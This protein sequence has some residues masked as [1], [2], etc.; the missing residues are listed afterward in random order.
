MSDLFRNYDK[1]E[2]NTVELTY[3]DML[4]HQKME[5]SILVLAHLIR[6]HI[7]IIFGI[8]SIN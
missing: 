6:N 2:N 8:L 1:N 7:D 3:R 5:L 4:I